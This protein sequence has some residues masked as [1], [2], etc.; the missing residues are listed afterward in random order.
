MYVFI[1]HRSYTHDILD[2]MFLGPESPSCLFQRHCRIRYLNLDP[3]LKSNAE[4]RN[5]THA[6]TSEFNKHTYAHKHA[7][8]HK[9]R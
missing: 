4:S 1:M 6:F 2:Y 9:K 8:K 5:A 3:M 7:S